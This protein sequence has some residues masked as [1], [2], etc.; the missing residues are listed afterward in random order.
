M[1]G[2][3]KRRIQEN[4]EVP[5]SRVRRK[6]LTTSVRRSAIRKERGEDWAVRMRQAF[7]ANDHDAALQAAEQVLARDPQNEEAREFAARCGATVSEV[8]L[9]MLGGE[10]ARFEVACS[11]PIARAFAADP[12]TSLLAVFIRSGFTLG[13]ILETCGDRRLDVLRVLD[14]LVGRGVLRIMAR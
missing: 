3:R 11:G 10:G 14:R 9:A 1:A 6:V 7:L 13:E 8:L 5:T 4:S 12:S 2:N